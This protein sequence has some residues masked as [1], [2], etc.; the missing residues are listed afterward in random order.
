MLRIIDQGILSREPGRGAYMPSISELSDG[1]LIAC[2]HVGRELA[3]A[4]NDI[5]LLTTPDGGRSWVNRG[6]IH[7][8]PL[9]DGWYYRGPYI[10]EAPD[11]RLLLTATR[12]VNTD[13]E[14]F[15][16]DTEALQRPEMLLY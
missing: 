2:Q 3:S 7:G 12:F 10:F 16:A 9:G 13:A 1:T 6:S 4:D 15:D 5:E 8:G 11:G 14:L